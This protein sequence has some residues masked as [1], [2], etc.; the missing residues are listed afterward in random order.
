M[1]LKINH[2]LGIVDVKFFN[3]FSLN[4]KYDSVAS[5]FAFNF[6]FD[7]KNKEH[8]ELACVSHFHEAIVEHNGETLITGYILSQ[9]FNS[10][11]KK[12]LVQVGGYSK[13]GVLEDC[14]IPTSLYPLQTD[15]LTFREIAQRLISPFKLK[16][17]VDEIARRDA[18]QGITVTEKADKKIDKSTAAESQNI[19]SYLTEL[20]AQRNIVLSHNEF[21]DLLLTEAN[22]AQ[23]PILHFDSGLI[24]TNMSMSF[25]GQGLHS[26]ITVIKQADD[27]G[28]N[29]GEVTIANPYVPI[30]YRPKV[31]TQTSGD[32]ITID[33]TAK[34]ALAAELKNIVLTITTDRWEVDGKIIRPNNIVTV[35]DPE[36]FIYQKTDWFIEEVSFTGDSKKTTA[37]LKCVLPEVYNGKTPKNIFVNP[38]ENLPRF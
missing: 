21:G 8:A 35:T 22:T 36:L 25:S 16:M 26:H 28:G 12:E 34:N 11:A 3:S 23:K 18:S 19:K 37:V 4:L 17:K 7:P 24:G 32:D 31:I 13:P 14:E 9:V 20:A 29:A 2:R 5:T 33:E 27:E 1:N 6:Y 38:H 10:S 30:V 15:G